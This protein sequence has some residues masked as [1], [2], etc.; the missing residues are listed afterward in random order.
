MWTTKLQ[1]DI[2]IEW[3]LGKLGP[4]FA[5]DPYRGFAHHMTNS[6]TGADGKSLDGYSNPE[7]DQWVDK[8]LRALNDKDID[9]CYQE[10]GKIL[11][12]DAVNIPL[13]PI[14][15]LMAYNKRIKGLKPNNLAAFYTTTNFE[16]WWIE[17]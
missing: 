9:R 8:A 7:F 5:A 15:Q 4:G 12:K 17:E 16:N 10:A 2:K 14:R 3:D 1:R 13:H 11:L 6:N